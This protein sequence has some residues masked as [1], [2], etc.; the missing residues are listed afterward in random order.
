MD[1]SSEEIVKTYTNIEKSFLK[2]FFKYLIMRARNDFFHLFLQNVK[3]SNN[4]S[5]IDVGT[6]PSLNIEQNFFLE[7]IKNNSNLTCISNQDC[8]ILKKKFKNI[9]KIIKS[10]F[11][12]SNLINNSFDISHSNATIEHVG[13]FNNQ[14]LFV[15][16]MLD[17]SKESIFIQT[18]NIFYPID[19]HTLL[20]FI[21][22]LPKKI[23]RKILKFLKLD[24]YSAESN[25]NLLT[26]NDL[27]SICK[28]LNVKKYKILKYRLFFFTSNLILIINKKDN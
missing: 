20:P 26:I 28:I 4:K 24:F 25:L 15:K 17:I 12:T 14:I 23:H 21:H 11:I 2:K 5:L 8:T 1:Q 13:S 19:F 6:T 7:C 3:Y 18:P 16:K 22:W 27:K 9:K 10:D